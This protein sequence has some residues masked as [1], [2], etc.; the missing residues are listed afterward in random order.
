MGERDRQTANAQCKESVNTVRLAYARGQE[1]RVRRNY[2]L[3]IIKQAFQPSDIPSKK[4][5]TRN[6]LCLLGSFVSVVW[7]QKCLTK[8]NNK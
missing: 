8:K 4:S 5:V 1:K 3:V 6:Y 2:S 7:R